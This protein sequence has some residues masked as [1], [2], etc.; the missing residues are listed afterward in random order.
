MNKLLFIIFIVISSTLYAKEFDNQSSM[1][2]NDTLY[3]GNNDTDSDARI[4]DIGI[5]GSSVITTQEEKVFGE[6]FFRKSRQH[7][8]IIDDP[9]LDEY[10]KTLG[11]QLISHANNVHFPFNFFLIKD[12]TINAAA[13]LGGNVK[14]NSGLFS[15][16]DNE[17][18]LASVIA[19]EITHVTQRHI[20][21]F[22]EDYSA[23]Q[24]K[25]IGA[26]IGGIILT[27]INPQLGMAVLQTTLALNIQNQI[28]YTRNDEFEADHIGIDLL[29][30]AN[31][32]PFEMANFFNKLTS[33]NYNKIPQGLL[34]HPIPQVRVADALNRA[35][36]YKKINVKNNENFSFAKARIE[37]RFSDLS[38]ED[39]FNNFNTRFK[40]L[41]QQKDP[42]Y[43]IYGL[44]LS[45]VDCKK[46]QI[47]EEALNILE[48]KYPNN[49]FLIDT[50]SD[51]N[52][53]LNKTES[54]ISRLKQRLAL[55]PQN[56]TLLLNLAV[57]YNKKLDYKNSIKCL[58][59]IISYNP[60]NLLVFNLLAHAYKKNNDKY[61][62]YR[63]MGQRFAIISEYDK[64]NQNLN[65]AAHYAK[66]RLDKAKINAMVIKNHQTKK[67]ESQFEK[68]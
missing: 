10:I 16:A 32:D 43:I 2:Q 4:P 68:F 48:K 66:N 18:Q 22:I 57:A 60:N 23:R 21:R 47:A 40:N 14:I 67:L 26:I 35:N 27:A 17:S 37:V 31:F 55:M 33:V 12:K 49:L 39:S 20:A 11:N 44:A 46:Y 58:E 51:I 29:Y 61:N 34:D 53:S 36:K 30:R 9:V 41:P 54:V 8:N 62:Y 59:K 42:N 15:I 56:T 1:F 7:L 6:Y 25:T 5:A 38:C 19:H 28:N 65:Y 24:H 63:I 3:F 45:S 13:F 50:Y 52:L 64:S